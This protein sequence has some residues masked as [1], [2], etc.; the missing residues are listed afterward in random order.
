MVRSP[1]TR[2]AIVIVPLLALTAVLSLGIYNRTDLPG[3]LGNVVHNA[4]HEVKN[5]FNSVAAL[6][7]A[8]SPGERVEG[9]LASLKARKRA[10]PHERALAKVRRPGQPGSL[11]SILSGP[12][13]PPF[14]IALEAPAPLFNVVTSP[15]PIVTPPDQ[16][17]ATP[18]GGPPLVT[19]PSIPLIVPPIVTP[20]I[21]PVTPPVSAVPEPASW[22]MML[23]GFAAIAHQLRKRRSSSNAI[24][25]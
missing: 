13:M 17:L 21:T 22:T 8:R 2:R 24:G 9:S 19:P 23:I 25:H 3:A 7:A 14:E 15:P 18:P 1:L 11:S 12:P 20:P 16:P 4:T 10:E 5:G 6:F